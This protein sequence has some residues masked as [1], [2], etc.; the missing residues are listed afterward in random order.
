[1]YR[2]IAD[3]RPKGRLRL[4]HLRVGEMQPLSPMYGSGPCCLVQAITRHTW[5]TPWLVKPTL[6]LVSRWAAQTSRVRV[7]AHALPSP[8]LTPHYNHWPYVRS[9]L[10]GGSNKYSYR[11]TNLAVSRTSYLLQWHTLPTNSRT[12]IP[13]GDTKK[14]LFSLWL[15]YFCEN[16]KPFVVVF[17][18]KFGLVC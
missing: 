11:R 12:N 15:V 14:N 8:P 1:M 13:S 5:E 10:V 16:N 6:H 2:S 17:Q 7:S 4:G 9:C 18:K 3:S